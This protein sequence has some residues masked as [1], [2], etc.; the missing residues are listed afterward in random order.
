MSFP[1]TLEIEAKYFLTESSF[2]LLLPQL[3]NFKLEERYYLISTDQGLELRITKS[4]AK[5]GIATATLDR[6]QI[7]PDPDL[8]PGSIRQKERIKITLAEFN[9]LLQLLKSANPTLQ[10]V[11]RE[12]YEL[13]TSGYVTQ[14]K[15]YQ[16]QFLGLIRAEFE[17]NSKSD[18]LVFAPPSWCGP[19]IT[20]TPLGSDTSLSM[21]L[22]VDFQKHLVELY[23]Q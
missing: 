18:L 20:S 1:N 19:N 23:I 12:H 22:P 8:P 21:L 5:N 2:N 6:M 14:I 10:P 4:T 7:L 17:F 15:R 13:D 11:V 3:T 9:A 16:N